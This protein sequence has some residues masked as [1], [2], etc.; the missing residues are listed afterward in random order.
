MSP[1]TLTLSRQASEMRNEHQCQPKLTG[2]PT[3]RRRPTLSCMITAQNMVH[4]RCVKE[5]M[6]GWSINIIYVISTRI[7]IM[8]IK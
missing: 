5:S 1:T 2:T 6:G 3:T 7:N 4:I 8:M